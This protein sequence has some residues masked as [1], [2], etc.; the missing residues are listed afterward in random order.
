[1]CI[2]LLN[3]YKIMFIIQQKEGYFILQ[4]LLC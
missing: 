3:I 1:M 2:L 4:N